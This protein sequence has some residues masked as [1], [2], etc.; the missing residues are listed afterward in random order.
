MPS[1]P[2]SWVAQSQKLDRAAKRKARGPRPEALIEKAIQEAFLL[3]YRVKLHKTDSGGIT[4]KRGA[5]KCP[6]GLL[7]A[8]G[9]PKAMPFGIEAWIA[10]PLGFSDLTGYLGG[11]RFIFIEVKAPGG[12][13]RPGQKE[14]LEARRAEGHVAFRAD[15]VESALSQFAQEAA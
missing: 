12:R 8:L 10:L 11:S 4:E 7:E 13:F 14:F 5:M 1:H 9:L 6:A 15:S 2:P 3:K